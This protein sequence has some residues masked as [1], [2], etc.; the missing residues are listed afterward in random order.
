MS[1][2]SEYPKICIHCGANFI[3]KKITTQFCSHKCSQR[4]YKRRQKEQRIEIAHREIRDANKPPLFKNENFSKKNNPSEQN[5]S[6]LNQRDF[7]SVAQ[8]ACIMG[9]GR[10]TAYNYCVSGKLKSIKMNRKIFVRR[11]DLEELFNTA[12][13]YEV[14]PRV[15]KTSGGKEVTEI[16]EE[17]FEFDSSIPITEFISAQDAAIRY[18]I[19]KDSIHAM[20]RKRN[21]PSVLYKGVKQYSVSHL[22]NHYQSA[23]IY[24]H[25]TQ[26][27]YV[28]EIM[29]KYGVSKSVV[30]GMV[31]DHKIPRKNDEGR[32]L[33]SK[34][35]VDKIMKSR[36]GDK[37]I[38]RWYNTK[39]LYELYG[40][41]PK[42]A[43]GFVYTNKIPK[44]RLDG[45]SEYSA[46]HFDRI[47]EERNPSTVY[48]KIED[49]AKRFDISTEKVHNL[50][51]QYDIPRR[52][53]GK[54]VRVQKIA[55]EGII[56]NIKL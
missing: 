43:A 23:D 26:W 10:T 55:I 39:E 32:N 50:I 42:Y 13:L 8:L 40:I 15:V 44:R 48:I 16:V 35:H 4:A 2:N 18:G 56:N 24:S 51:K 20:A 6:S 25:I 5:L 38:K 12:P 54:Y 9:T 45:K 22:D 49:A 30:Y 33:Y 47:I 41:S 11:K 28:D 34:S 27:Y 46:D 3:A 21:L 36:L 53:D 52:K 29:E 37:S 17:I 14:T 31:S 19:S 7:L 1:S